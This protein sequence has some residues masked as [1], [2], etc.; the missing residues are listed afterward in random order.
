[1]VKEGPEFDA[2]ICSSIEHGK[3]YD[4]LSIKPDFAKKASECGLGSLNMMLGAFDGYEVK[5]RL[6]SYEGP[7][8]VGY[9]VA[10]FNPGNYSDDRTFAT[11]LK[12]K[13]DREFKAKRRSEDP[14]VKLARESLEYYIK[15]HKQMQIPIDIER[16]LVKEKA[17]VFV[18]LHLNGK[19]RGCI[20]TIQ[21]TT[22]SIAEEIIQNAISSGT[23]DYR[24]AKV[25]LNEL[26]RIEY[27]VDVLKTPESISDASELDVKTYGVIVSNQYKSGLL[28]PNIEGIETVEE[29]IRIAKMKAG[30]KDDEPYQLQ[31]FEVVRHH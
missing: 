16:Q 17:G 14:Y 31:R 10:T 30:I 24:F 2:L 3:F 6:L 22:S 18:T 25:R 8:G 19:L 20:G 4:I 11:K 27:S 12:S 21:P 28:L 15:H 9:C 13:R 29:Q 23:R 7:F 1:M 26:D 5:S